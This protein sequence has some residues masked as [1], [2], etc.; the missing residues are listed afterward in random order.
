MKWNFDEFDEMKVKM[1]NMQ[2]TIDSMLKIEKCNDARHQR[3]KENKDAYYMLMLVQLS[4]VVL[5][6][7]VHACSIHY[8]ENRFDDPLEEWKAD[9]KRYGEDVER[10]FFDFGKRINELEFNQEYGLR[11][12]DERLRA[13]H[14][15]Q[16]VDNDRIRQLEESVVDLENWQ[17]DYIHELGIDLNEYLREMETWREDTQLE[18][19][20]LTNQING[21]HNCT[22]KSFRKMSE[23]LTTPSSWKQTFEETRSTLK[24]ISPGNAYF[25]SH[26][27]LRGLYNIANVHNRYLEQANDVTNRKLHYLPGVLTHID[28]CYQ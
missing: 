25:D 4:L 10:A 21:H 18:V 8:S 9:I 15:K 3:E 23:Y 20:E 24:V 5:C 11:G 14:S 13:M 6:V 19:E 27:T 1:D 26:A 22:L 12:F 28:E 17:V 16:M 2:S 7:C